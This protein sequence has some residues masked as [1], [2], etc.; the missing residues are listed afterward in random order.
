MN[1]IE[2]ILKSIGAP[3]KHLFYTGREDPYITYQ[4]YNEYGKVFAEDKEVVTAYSVQINIFTKG[5]LEDLYKQVLDLMIVA[6]WCRT[7]ATE[8]YE[9]DTKLNHKIIRFKYTEEH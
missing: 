1:D 6:G 4:F 3:I 9:T 2:S 8:D 5:K 7:Y